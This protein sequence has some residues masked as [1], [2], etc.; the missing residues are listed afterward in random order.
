VFASE[1]FDKQLWIPLAL[2][3]ALLIV[4]DSER[5]TDAHR[6]GSR[7]ASPRDRSDPSRP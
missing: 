3:P 6:T 7:S 2:G 4:A 1:M 5:A